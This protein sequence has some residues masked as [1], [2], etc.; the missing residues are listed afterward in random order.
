MNSDT[1]T[2]CPLLIWA[3][4]YVGTVA[5]GD[6]LLRLA[7]GRSG[8]PWLAYPATVSLVAVWVS[9]VALEVLV[10]RGWTCD[11]VERAGSRFGLYALS[12]IVGIFVWSGVTA[13]R[14]VPL[15]YRAVVIGLF[16]VPLVALA[17]SHS[18][19]RF[20][21]A[22]RL[23]ARVPVVV[24]LLIIATLLFFAITNHM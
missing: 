3:V 13:E 16:V 9:A 7:A 23:V 12:F 24:L 6:V 14:N 4:A 5:G 11:W 15:W 1:E 21:K 8:T 18:T 19:H 2:R 22:L 17:T 10:S 20:G